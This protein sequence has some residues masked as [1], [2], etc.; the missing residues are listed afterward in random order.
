MSQDARILVAAGAS[1]AVGGV[2]W[3]LFSRGSPILGMAAL[4]LLIVAPAAFNAALIRSAPGATAACLVSALV[5]VLTFAG[6][7]AVSSSQDAGHGQLTNYMVAGVVM[8]ILQF[9]AN[10]GAVQLRRLFSD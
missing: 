10:L 5:A 7:A 2:S 6:G 1:A 9:G 4:L 8:V 3:T